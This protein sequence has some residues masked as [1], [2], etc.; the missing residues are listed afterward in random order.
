MIYWVYVLES[1]AD[2]SQYVGS[3][4]DVSHR[5]AQH[6]DGRC[7]ATE[8]DRPWRLI[9][10]EEHPTRTAA[11][12]RQEFFKTG[13]GKDLLKRLARTGKLRISEGA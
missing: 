9:Y 4:H 7:P 1:L 12:R 6:N 11:I 10:E 2:K 3:T 13:R 8:E 5:L